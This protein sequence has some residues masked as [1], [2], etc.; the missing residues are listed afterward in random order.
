[1]RIVAIFIL[2]LALIFISTLD[3]AN[4]KKS[5][6]LLAAEKKRLD[7]ENEE[8]GDGILKIAKDDRAESDDEK[9]E[10]EDHVNVTWK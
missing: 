3:I 9:D 10:A 4:Q 1:M 2:D 6:A 7:R 8:E 5:D